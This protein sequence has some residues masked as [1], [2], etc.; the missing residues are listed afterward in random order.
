ME[1]AILQV[2]KALLLVMGVLSVASPDLVMDVRRRL[3]FGTG[4]WSG[5]WV[6]ATRARTRI[7][8]ALLL[9]ALAITWQ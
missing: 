3:R 8:G 1:H 6:Y 9:V 4:Y 2:I 7:S 5:G